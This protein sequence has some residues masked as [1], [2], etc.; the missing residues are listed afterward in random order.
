[1]TVWSEWTVQHTTHLPFRNKQRDDFSSG[2]RYWDRPPHSSTINKCFHR[3][4]LIQCGYV[5]FQGYSSLWPINTD[6]EPHPCHLDWDTCDSSSPRAS[7]GIYSLPQTTVLPIWFLQLCQEMLI[8]EA[9]S[10]IRSRYLSLSWNLL[11]WEPRIVVEWTK[12]S[13]TSRWNDLFYAALME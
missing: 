4:H 12:K 11:S 8:F 10:N 3:G 5:F 2:R 13:G 7:F 6:T 1:M 9:P